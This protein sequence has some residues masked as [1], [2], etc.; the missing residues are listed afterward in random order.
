MQTTMNYDYSRLLSSEIG[1]HRNNSQ[2]TTEIIVL[3]QFN[4]SGD[5][6]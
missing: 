1:F 4:H 6:Q 3:L 2:H 5:G